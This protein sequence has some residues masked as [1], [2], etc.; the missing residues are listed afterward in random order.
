ML[1]VL[2]CMWR[3]VLVCQNVMLRVTTV[4][5]CGGSCCVLAAQVALL[6]DVCCDD[7]LVLATPRRCAR[8]MADWGVPGDDISHM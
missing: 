1:R 8:Q 3:H 4:G 5:M 7:L 2:T 6:V